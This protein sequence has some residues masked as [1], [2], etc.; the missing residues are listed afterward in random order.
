MQE[1]CMS[2][3]N[4]QKIKIYQKKKWKGI[5]AQARNHKIS[6]PKSEI[7][8]PDWESLLTAGKPLTTVEARSSSGHRRT[9]NHPRRWLSR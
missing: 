4:M 6:N 8:K 5:E 2:E 3:H 9:K 1:S 7:E